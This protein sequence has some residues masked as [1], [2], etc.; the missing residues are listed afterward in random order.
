M[1]TIPAVL[2]HIPVVSSIA[3]SV[4]IPLTVYLNTFTL[5]CTNWVITNCPTMIGQLRGHSDVQQQPSSRWPLTMIL[6]YL[7]EIVHKNIDIISENLSIVVM[8]HSPEVYISWCITDGDVP[9]SGCTIK[10]WV[11]HAFNW[12]KRI[13]QRSTNRTVVEILKI[14]RWRLLLWY[15]M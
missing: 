1:T 3:I 13:S 12:H 2:F 6:S 15:S 8:Y 11:I 7:Q 5:T 9:L 14:A 10:L 4:A